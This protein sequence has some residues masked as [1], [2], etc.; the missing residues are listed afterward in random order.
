MAS[1]EFVMV[2]G[3]AIAAL[4]PPKPEP[5]DA[6]DA[7]DNIDKDISTL[8]TYRVSD[9]AEDWNIK[10]A[11]TPD[12]PMKLC[13]VG[14]SQLSGKTNLIGNLLMLPHDDYPKEGALTN[15]YGRDFRGDDIYVVCPSVHVDHKWMQIIKY[16]GIPPENV[17]NE[18][19][20][21]RLSQLVDQIQHHFELAI[22]QDRQPRHSLLILDDCSFSGALK[23]KIAGVISRCFCNAR[24]ILLS[25]IVSAQKYTDLPRVARINA[26]GVFVSQDVVGDKQHHLEMG[27]R[28]KYQL[29]RDLTAKATERP[30]S[31]FISMPRKGLYAITPTGESPDSPYAWW[32]LRDPSK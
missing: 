9:K 11:I 2:P 16:K 17:F 8:K 3:E 24:H 12:L 5:I 4:E 15:Y 22:S 23:H 19:S 14:R 25:T 18:Y 21:E 28:F 20:E 31:W 6:K 10:K 30:F 32:R 13:I 7:F 27:A 29:W 26:T 1:E